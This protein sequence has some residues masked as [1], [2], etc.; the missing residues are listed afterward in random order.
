MQT[1]DPLNNIRLKLKA[2]KESSD[3]EIERFNKIRLVANENLMEI[4][5]AL[6]SSQ[7]KYAK[8]LSLNDPKA[9]ERRKEVDDLQSQY[10]I[11]QIEQYKALNSYYQVLSRQLG[12]FGDFEVSRINDTAEILVGLVNHHWKL[13]NSINSALNGVFN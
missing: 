6:D 2:V 9:E 8:A 13:L 11:C 7:Q 3:S 1:A 12:N 4:T 5:K 10:E